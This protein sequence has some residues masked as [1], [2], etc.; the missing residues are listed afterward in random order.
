VKS[1]AELPLAPIQLTDAYVYDASLTRR[2][3]QPDVDVDLPKLG[4]LLKLVQQVAEDQVAIVLEAQ[5][6]GS[7]NDGRAVA[8]LVVSTAGTFRIVDAAAVDLPSFVRREAVLLTYPYLRSHV[9]QIWRLAAIPMPPLP[10]LDTWQTI[11]MIDEA[12]AAADAL[13]AAPPAKAKQTRARKRKS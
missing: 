7:F 10:T 9:G 12:V 13:T 1:A 4:V 6:E 5:V 8:T 11:Q 2:D 3:I